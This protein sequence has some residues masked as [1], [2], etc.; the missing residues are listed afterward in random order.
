[1]LNKVSCSHC[2]SNRNPFFKHVVTIGWKISKKT[3]CQFWRDLPFFWNRK[4]YFVI[5]LQKGSLCKRFTSSNP[6]ANQRWLL[7]FYFGTKTSSVSSWA[8]ASGVCGGCVV[9][10]NVKHFATQEE[11]FS[12]VLLELPGRGS[13]NERN[14]VTCIQKKRRNVFVNFISYL[15]CYSFFLTVFFAYFLLLFFFCFSYFI[16]LIYFLIF[17][18]SLLP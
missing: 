1:M 6:V 5:T 18:F 13:Y 2:F 12:L 10:R 15:L 8:Y 9:H 3:F 17:P 14:W 7:L 11:H 16:F 4:K